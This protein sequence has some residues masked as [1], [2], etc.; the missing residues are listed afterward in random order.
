GL[1]TQQ[2]GIAGF[3]NAATVTVAAMFVL[4]AGAYRTGLVG[5]LGNLVARAYRHSLGIAV[6][7]TML[8]VGLLSAFVNNTPVVAIFIPILLEISRKLRLSP[9]RLLMP[10]SYA[11]MFGGVC[12]LVGTSTNILVSSIAESHGLAPFGMFEFTPMGVVFFA[13]G[14][15]YMVTLGL[16]LIP[17]RGR[18]PELTEKFGLGDYLIEV[19]LQPASRSVGRTVADSPLVRDLG[20]QIVDVQRA[21]AWL[22]NPLARQI[23]QAGD[24]L[25]LIGG[26]E[27]VLRLQKEP[28]VELRPHR[29]WRD[30]DLE[31]GETVLVEAVIA[32]LSPLA[33]QTLQEVRFRDAFGATVLAIRHR[34]QL[35]QTHL[36]KIRLRSGDALLLDVPRRRLAR[37][38]ESEAFVFVSAVALPEF[39]ESKAFLALAVLV[40]V[41]VLA[42]AGVVPIVTGAIAGCA[43][44]VLTGCLT[45]AEAYQA[46]DWKV[47]FLL[48]GTLTLGVALERTGAAQYAAS[49]L[50]SA[51]GDWGPLALLAAFYLI[52]TFLTEV[53]SNN[54]AAVLLAPIAIS[55]ADLLGLSPRPL[56]I[57]VAFAASSSFMTPV[58][59]QTNTMIYGVG[60]Y[61]FADFLRVGAPLNLLFWTL[62]TLLIPRFWP[63]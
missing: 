6:S 32:P 15:L 22:H 4:S 29:K 26:V 33:G 49:L 58:G 46:I 18:E 44:L 55:T 35:R 3:S 43:V 52:T 61:R 60:R 13:F 9:S 59:Y 53:M 8:G 37:L 48:A 62:A 39:R 16:K 17:E 54:A 56:L 45:L 57:A 1:V 30:R 14:I 23:L 12:T 31:A 10:V 11:A 25:R 7:V 47:I 63:F 40:A 34:G 19:I 20:V 28:G 51:I 21:G 50:I 42:A 41:V 5:R 24:V 27:T 2:D 38:S 36:E